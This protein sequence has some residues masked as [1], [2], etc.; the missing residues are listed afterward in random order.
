MIKAEEVVAK[1]LLQV[2]NLNM[3]A[4]R[5]E[6]NGR[7]REAT[8]DRLMRAGIELALNALVGPA[9]LRKLLD[10]L[11]E[12]HAELKQDQERGMVSIMAALKD[13]LVTTE[14][15]AH[16]AERF[17]LGLPVRDIEGRSGLV[18]GYRAEKVLV[19]ETGVPRAEVLPPTALDPEYLA[20][21]NQ[22]PHRHELLAAVERALLGAAA[23]GDADSVRTLAQARAL[24]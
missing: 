13:L 18:V 14:P 22:R 2:H 12:H 20:P 9:L 1:L 17:P 24:L 21:A 15:P 10:L 11:V 23:R 6:R 5:W 4:D 19:R 7:D 8:S 3:S 16:L